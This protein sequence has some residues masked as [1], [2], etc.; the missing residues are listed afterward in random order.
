MS[1]QTKTLNVSEVV[2]WCK[3]KVIN[4]KR[5]IVEVISWS[6]YKWELRL[7]WDWYFKYRAALMQVKYPKL[8]VQFTWG[9]EPATGKTLQ[10]IQSDKIR[11]KRSK[12]SQ[13][14]NKLQKARDHWSSLFPIEDDEHYQ[15]A[16]EKIKKLE[17]ELAVMLQTIKQS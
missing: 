17:F 16:C 9:S 7:K 10:Q 15:K 3:I 4:E 11:A 14:K 8:E 6:G 5:E 12:I 2:H 13:Y 1:E